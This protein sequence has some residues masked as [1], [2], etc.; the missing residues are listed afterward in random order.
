MTTICAH[1]LPAVDSGGGA[2]PDSCT[3]LANRLRGPAWRRLFED[4]YIHVDRPV[5]HAL[6]ARAAAAMVVPGP[7]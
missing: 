3:V 1:S 7:W 2:G 4:V 6:R 5:S